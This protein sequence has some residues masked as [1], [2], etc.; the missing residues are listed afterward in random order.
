MF[1]ARL[2]LFVMALFQTGILIAE[3]RLFRCGNEYTNSAEQAKERGCT[4]VEYQVPVIL[5]DGTEDV[6]MSSGLKLAIVLFVPAL[7]ILG[8]R[9]LLKSRDNV[10][11]NLPDDQTYALVAAAF[12]Y[13]RI[14][15]NS[16]EVRSFY[17]SRSRLR[18]VGAFRAIEADPRSSA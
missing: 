9:M 13:L 8:G 6:Q 18:E 7:L 12:I 3:D 10:A 4:E 5:S 14:L 2:L 17:I 11:V 16:P 15:F 1:V